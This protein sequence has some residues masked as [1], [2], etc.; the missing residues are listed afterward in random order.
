MR[1]FLIPKSLVFVLSFWVV[2]CAY[3]PKFLSLTETG[4]IIEM[5]TMWNSIPNTYPSIRQYCSSIGR[6]GPT[7]SESREHPMYPQSLR[8]SYP[9]RNVFSFNCGAII[10]NSFI[11]RVGN[12][13]PPSAP[14]VIPAPPP[15]PVATES[16]PPNRLS[17][18][19][20]K[21]K[22]SELGFK[23]STEGFGKCVLQLTK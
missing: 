5:D 7:G 18:D 10:N 11:N 15:P 20:A 17:L 16:P 21:E 3:N 1:I 19:S 2:G 8:R 14:V 23:S 12:V 6:Q 9:D 22:C 4:G 13:A